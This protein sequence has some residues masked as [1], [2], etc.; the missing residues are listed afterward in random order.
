MWLQDCGILKKLRDDELKVPNLIPR[1]KMK[2]NHPISL[3]QLA[4]SFFMAVPGIV[5]AISA[6]FVELFKGQKVK[7]KG[8]NQRH[9][10]WAAPTRHHSE[11]DVRRDT[12]EG[13]NIILPESRGPPVGT[14]QP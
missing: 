13:Q 11:R 2:L 10:S 6:F 12:T 7:A 5:I 9:V 3:S 14:M 1:P 4:M 8:T